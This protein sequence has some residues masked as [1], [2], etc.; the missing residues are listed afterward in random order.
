MQSNLEILVCNGE[1]N[2]L[3]AVLFELD[4]TI[5]GPGSS[6]CKTI[7]DIVEVAGDMNFLRDCLWNVSE[8]YFE[9]R[10]EFDRLWAAAEADRAKRTADELL[11]KSMTDVEYILTQQ[12]GF[13]IAGGMWGDA[14][15][16]IHKDKIYSLG[17]GR[18]GDFLQAPYDPQAETCV[19]IYS[20]PFDANWDPKTGEPPLTESGNIPEFVSYIFPNLFD[21]LH[22]IG[23]LFRAEPWNVGASAEDEQEA[24]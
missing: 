10:A 17:Q 15:W 12:S 6:P 23:W 2:T 11:R 19:W 16:K 13:T 9:D 21:A 5:N 3:R 7:K 24:A 14:A 8:H 22:T 18:T 4:H 1:N 20:G